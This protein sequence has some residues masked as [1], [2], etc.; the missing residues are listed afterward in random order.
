MNASAIGWGDLLRAFAALP[1]ADHEA[2]AQALG[3]ERAGRA[4][5]LPPP[6][7]PPAPPPAS[8][9]PPS[10]LPPAAPRSVATAPRQTFWRV[11]SDVSDPTAQATAPNW[12]T[13]MDTPGFEDFEGE[14]GVAAPLVPPLVTKGRLASFL[15]RQL[16]QLRCTSEP[17]VARLLRLLSR[18]LPI[19]RWPMR[20]RA[21]WPAQVRVLFDSSRA[22]QPLDDDLR[23]VVEELHKTLGQRLQLVM[24]DR[25]RLELPHDGRTAVV[26]LG[27]AGLSRCALSESDYGTTL[28]HWADFGRR[29]ERAGGRKALLLAPL[30]RR[31]VRR[32]MAEAFDIALLSDD[33]FPMRLIRRSGW[34]DRQVPVRGCDAEVLRAALFGHPCV[35]PPVLR[36]LR[37]TLSRHGVHLDMASELAVWH[38]PFISA[39][40]TACT[41]LSERRDAVRQQFLALPSALRFAAVGVLWTHLQSAS[42]LVRAEYARWVAPE[43]PEGHALTRALKAGL[44]AA[45]LLARRMCVAIA[46]GAPG[47]SRDLSA[48]LS[49][50]G[51]RSLAL[52]EQD[53]DALQTAWLLAHRDALQRQTTRLPAGLNL[54]AQSWLLAG[55]DTRPMAL[56]LEQSPPAQPGAPGLM[57]LRLAAQGSDGTGVCLATDLPGMAYWSI[58]RH[59]AQPPEAMQLGGVIGAAVRHVGGDASRAKALVGQLLRDGTLAQGLSKTVA[60]GLGLALHKALM[61]GDA[62]HQSG[63]RQW[64]A[65]VGAALGVSLLDKVP[66]RALVDGLLAALPEVVLRDDDAGVRTTAVLTSQ[67]ATDLGIGTTCRVVVGGRSL[68]LEAFQRPDWAESIWFDRGEWHAA[69]PDSRELVWTPTGECSFVACWWDAENRRQWRRFPENSWATRRGSDEFGNWAEFTLR[70]RRGPVTQRLRWIPPGEFLMGSP[71]SEKERSTN[72]DYTEIQHA[73]L[74]TQGYWLAD[75]ACTQELWEAVMDENPSRFKDDPQNP[76]EQV[77]WDD[78]TQ[79]FLPRLNKLVPGLNLTLPTEAQWE[80]ACRAGTTTVFSF[81][82]QITPEQVNYNGNHPY[83]D[84]KKGEYRNKTVPVKELPANQWGLHQ[85]HGN[86]WEWCMDEFAAYPEGTV[87][88]PVIHQDKIESWQRVLRGGS[89]FYYGR[90]CR[91]AYRFALVPDNRGR[92]FGFRLARGLADQPDQ[93]RH[94]GELNQKSKK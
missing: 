77:S 41:L 43:L 80:Y 67:E 50:L 53:G 51:A 68:E 16:V 42:P 38:D 75:T 9:P 39:S 74:L 84:G 82:D 36:A 59:V 48:Y 52:V 79:K 45:D 11:A 35:T 17:D 4:L 10:L 92:N 94:F 20:E 1:E 7:L 73:V 2:A 54:A 31:M 58:T 70:G 12:F 85:M 61:G 57:Q 21:A 63:W 28:A 13:Q 22:L 37:R 87:I 91:S 65:P 62:E 55:N 81:G 14:L 46:R 34:P 6:T 40:A 5:A 90:Y 56:L 19:R 93:P 25:R 69:L 72:G 88:D 71:E 66:V 47:L 64:L 30:P 29:I 27:D 89:W 44:E 18:Q 60:A 49:R 23:G 86:V 83:A 3:F 15:R 8:P 33:G 78:I 26:V 24:S 32:E 76:V